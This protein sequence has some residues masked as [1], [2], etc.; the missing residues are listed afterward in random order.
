MSKNELGTQTSPYLLQ[1]AD[2]PVHWQ[3]WGDEVFDQARS[4]DKP[5]LLSIGYAACHWCH[6]MAHESFEDDESAEVM[7]RLFINVKVDREEHPD[8][9]GIYQKALSV[10]GQQGGWPLTMFLTPEG[11]PF[12]G[13]TYFPKEAMYGRPSFK[14]VLFSISDIYKTK[15]DDV[16]NNVGAITDA[17]NENNKPRGDGAL[18]LAQLKSVSGY[19]AHN[20]DSTH[21]GLAGAP[22]FPQPVLFDF[23]WRVSWINKDQSLQ[24]MIE[25]TLDKMC[26]GG[27]YDHLGG[28]F[29]RYSTDAEWLVPHFE[30]M[31]YDNAQLI[32]LLSMVWRKVPSPLYKIT[33]R[34][35]IDWALAEMKVETTDG[36][37]LA[38]ALDAD[39][40]GVEGKFYVW[41][42]EEIDELLG[43]ES[44]AFKK[45]YDVTSYGNWEGNTILR[46]ITEFENINA[47][48]R[49][50]ANR[51]KL[52]AHRQNRIAPGR[53]DKVLTDW[54][55]MMVKAL[56]EASSVFQDRTWLED[57]K[58]IFSSLLGL[59]EK[60]GQLHHSWCGGKL[61][62]QAYLE[63]Y[64]NLGLAAVALF[65]VTGEE[66][67]LKQAKNWVSHLDSHFWDK[68]TGG[69]MISAHQTVPGLE[70]APKP[71]HDNATPAGNGLMA[72]LLCLLH[73]FT[74]ETIYQDRFQE[75]IKTFGSSDPN[76]IFGSPGLCSALIQNEKMETI[77][78][79]GDRAK[80]DTKSLIEKAFHYPSPHRRILLGEGLGALQAS[81]PL[82][83]KD[84]VDDKATA[85]VC[86]VG[87]CSPPV[88]DLDVLEDNLSSLPL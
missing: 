43:E 22:K 86:Q 88:T 16:R 9:D 74:G 5:I 67:Y 52:Y 32:S 11:Q 72:N 83:G 62:A 79:I 45:A 57:A 53:D 48:N 69:Y 14:E 24:K 60:D 59:M 37:A 71:I 50:T 1:H 6:V 34:E 25:L 61:G 54:N 36:F 55:A 87:S 80:S 73:H 20:L 49:L 13:G 19:I 30:K 38:A 41:S 2:N 68:E 12:W 3:P 29:A 27:I 85:Y 4:L 47:E 84:M 35:T 26:L 17:L 7:N 70:V 23:L 40:E 31:L 75:M 66:S 15:Q 56:C 21:G 39:S 65:E 28:G 58:T 18:S 77:A 82:F 63:D 81:H 76:E 51:K 10:L 78:I 33:V 46:R 42:E 64:A 44:D 8:V